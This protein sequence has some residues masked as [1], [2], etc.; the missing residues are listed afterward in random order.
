M[1]LRSRSRRG[2][3]TTAGHGNC[4]TTR[5]HERRTATHKFL[6]VATN[7]AHFVATTTDRLQCLRTYAATNTSSDPSLPRLQGDGDLWCAAC[8]CAVWRLQLRLARQQVLPEMLR[9]L[10]V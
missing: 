6:L 5:R 2:G 10:A 3:S 8:L 7:R 9:R 1:P 4:R